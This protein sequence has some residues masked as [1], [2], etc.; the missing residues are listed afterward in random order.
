MLMQGRPTNGYSPAMPLVM[1]ATAPTDHSALIQTQQEAAS[2]PG[3]V[4][5]AIGAQRVPSPQM[6][7]PSTPQTGAERELDEEDLIEK[8][9]RKLTRLLAIESERR[10]WQRWP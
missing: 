4:V 2:S 9:L 5:P 7:S 10:G 6:E 8:V 1:T 3:A